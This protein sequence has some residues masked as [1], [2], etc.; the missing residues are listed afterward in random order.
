MK[1]NIAKTNGMSVAGFIFGLFCL[2]T[3]FVISFVPLFAGLSICLSI[4]SRGDQRMNWFAK[5][6]IIFSVTGM[7]LAFVE[8]FAI[9]SSL[10]GGLSGL[11]E[12]LIPWTDPTTWLDFSR[13][14]MTIFV[15]L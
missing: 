10:P 11:F 5:F 15:S 7:I 3:A 2:L 14:L 1:K 6:G 9:L 13:N 12:R 8:G 4:L